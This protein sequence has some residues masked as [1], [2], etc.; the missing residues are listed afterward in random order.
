MLILLLIVL[1]FSP[2][3]AEIKRAGPGMSC[4]LTRSLNIN[5]LVDGSGIIF[6]GKFQEAKYKEHAGLYVRELKFK[7]DEA[8]KGIETD[9]KFITLMEYAKV[10]SPFVDGQVKAGE[11]Y[12]FFFHKPSF[13]GLTSLRGM[14]QGLVEITS[15]TQLRYS[16]RLKLASNKSSNNLLSLART[17]SESNIMDSY[18]NLREFCVNRSKK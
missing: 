5:D 3:A 8:I 1:S 2:V 11:D 17:S 14:E 18:A 16:K 4:L 9:S 15:P 10:R 13:K 12:V 6:K 7:L